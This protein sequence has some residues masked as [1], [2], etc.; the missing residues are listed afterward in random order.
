MS[1]KDDE[2]DFMPCF[3]F[4]SVYIGDV[5]FCFGVLQNDDE[6]FHNNWY[7]TDT[8]KSQ[9]AMLLSLFYIDIYYTYLVKENIEL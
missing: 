4:T 6:G 1:G 3:F 8:A 7:S 9:G 2:L 5:S